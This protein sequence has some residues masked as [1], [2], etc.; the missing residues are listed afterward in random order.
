M[1]HPKNQIGMESDLSYLPLDE[2]A[3]D[4]FIWTYTSQEFTMT[5][6]NSIVKKASYRPFP[7]NAFILC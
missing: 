2:P 6:V 1:G 4:K 5:Q 7:V 3:D